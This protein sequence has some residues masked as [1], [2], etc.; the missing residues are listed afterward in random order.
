MSPKK[1]IAVLVASAS[2]AYSV[3]QTSRVDEN[4]INTS[5]NSTVFAQPRIQRQLAL[6]EV[7]FRQRLA[8]N[9]FK[10]AAELADQAVALMPE[11]AAVYYHRACVR[12]KTGRIAAAIQDLNLALDFGLR[13]ENLFTQQ[14][15]F[16]PL[17]GR[18]GWSAILQRSKMP[19][20]RQPTVAGKIENGV[21]T[22]DSSNTA[23][24]GKN[25]F[26][27]S[28]AADHSRAELPIV[29][30]SDPVAKLLSQWDAEG[31]AAGLA[32]ILYDNH[33]RLHSDMDWKRFPQLTRIKYTRAAST[34][35]LDS[36]LQ[37]FFHFNRTTFGNS[38]TAI[39]GNYAWRSQPRL[40]YVDASA[41]ASLARMYA[42][43]HF[44]VYP[45]HNDYDLGRN[46]RGGYGDVYPANTP[47]VLISQ[48]SSYSDKPFLT[49]IASTLAAFRPEVLRKLEDNRMVFPCMQMILRRC[50]KTIKTDEDYLTGN[51]H[52]V[53]FDGSQLN[54]ERMV[55][56]AHEIES[57]NV[58]PV[59]K[60][61][62][63]DE[64]RGV[65]GKDYFDIG[66]KE[67]LFTTDAAI[68]RVFRS[69]GQSKT[70][71][72]SAAWSDDANNRKLK[73]K[74]VVLQGDPDLISIKPGNDNSSEVTITVRHHERRLIRPGSKMETNRVDI[75]AFVN[76]GSYYSA[77]AF[78]T[79]YFPDDEERLYDE[80]GRIHSVVYTD[81]ED[82]GNYADPLL[83]T[84]KAW[85][86]VYRYGKRGELRGWLR[87]YRDRIE[88]FSSTGELVL[89]R[90][91][92]GRPATGRVLKY[93]ATPRK[94][95]APLLK[96][97]PTDRVVTYRYKSDSDMVG[98][99]VGDVDT[100]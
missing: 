10:S 79:F 72:V 96:S 87:S 18:T 46:G 65:N 39:V 83:V 92:L 31:T 20:V 77:P 21:A 57:L 59:C 5:T 44:Y 40:A 28:F 73:W 70:M 3:V 1:I 99:V 4:D 35:N 22:V 91:E 71:K 15:A 100:E 7:R 11:T 37:M 42:G 24:L 16:R 76:N 30:G 75:G 48:G 93:L 98:T 51:A 6:F 56:M 67:E 9:D 47:F 36:G 80:K 12:V 84:P 78:V 54:V 38:S 85:T 88:E 82:G 86:D 34:E 68:A 49:A 23:Y 53:V 81:L 94:N 26:A 27:V 29:V 89:T 2:I 69:V 55:L 41:V 19:Q 8:T 50:L 90:D 61:S 58:P 33:D 14:T 45:E 32:N 17:N 43:N 64:Q 95:K 66:E 63:L 25:Q 52:P 97:R 13:G 74:W 62:V 60:L